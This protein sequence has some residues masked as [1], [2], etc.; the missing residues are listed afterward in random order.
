MVAVGYNYY[1]SNNKYV[2]SIHSEK[3]AI[4]ALPKRPTNKKL[5][6]VDIMIVKSSKSGSHVGNSHPCIGCVK[7]LNSLPA[8]YGYKIRKVHFTNNDGTIT[9]MSLA[10]LNQSKNHFKSKFYRLNENSAKGLLK[11][12]EN[13]NHNCCHHHSDDEMEDSE[14]IDEQ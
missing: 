4:L 9:S 1:P 8:R 14:E 13:I 10:S 5:K 3:A 7:D 6:K 11:N 2:G 12:T